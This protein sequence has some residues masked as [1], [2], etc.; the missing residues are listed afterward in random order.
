M[1]IYSRVQRPQLWSKTEHQGESCYGHRKGKISQRWEVTRPKDRKTTYSAGATGLPTVKEHQDDF[2]EDSKSQVGV[3]RLVVQR[4]KDAA[5]SSLGI[6]AT[7]HIGSQVR[8]QGGEDD[9]GFCATFE[10]VGRRA[11]GDLAQDT[12]RPEDIA[13][14]GEVAEEGI[15]L[16]EGAGAVADLALDGAAE[17]LVQDDDDGA[18]AE[19]VIAAVELE[20]FE[21]EVADGFDEGLELAVFEGVELGFGF[22]GGDGVFG[23]EDGVLGGAGAGLLCCG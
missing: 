18:A 11:R 7:D 13:G 8:D 4:G 21:E 16:D 20:G 6:R 1:S 15:V 19:P 2:I 17:E 10:T 9:G 23:G 3:Q 12:V 22:G 5:R 14:E